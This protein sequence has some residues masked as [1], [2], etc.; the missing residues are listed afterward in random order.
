[1]KKIGIILSACILAFGC[2][3]YKSQVEKLTS[4]K[5][6]LAQESRDKDVAINSFVQSFNEIEENLHQIELKQHIIAKNSN[7]QSKCNN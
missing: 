1:M 3:D 7:D 2:T 4:E 5:Q 6:A